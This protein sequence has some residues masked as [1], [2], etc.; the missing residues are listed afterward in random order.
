M[1]FQT[2]GAT[3]GERLTIALVLLGFVIE[4]LSDNAFW[5]RST[6]MTIEAC[7]ELCHSEMKPVHRVEAWA[8]ECGSGDGER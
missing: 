6:P 4:M 7:V 3:P 2:T 5:S 8:C 1:T